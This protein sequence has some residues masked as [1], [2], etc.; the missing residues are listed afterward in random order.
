MRRAVVCRLRGGEVCIDASRP[1]ETGDL[2]PRRAR[3]PLPGIGAPA[4]AMR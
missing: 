2:T 1:T 4:P 3:G